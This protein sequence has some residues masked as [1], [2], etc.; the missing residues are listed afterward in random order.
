MKYK[1]THDPQ[2]HRQESRVLRHYLRL[3]LFEKVILINSIML[4]GEALAGLWVT[5][6]SLESHH[7]LID[8]SF[9]VIA[10]LCSLIINILVLRASFRPLFRLLATMHA[11]SEGKTG[12]RT[13]SSSDPDIGQLARAFNEM[14]DRLEVIQHEQT[15]QILQAQ[16]EERRR[17]ARELHDE[18]SQTLTALLIHNEIL[19]Q[20]LA[21]FSSTEIAPVAREQLDEGLHVFATLAQDTLD[22]IRVLSQQLRPSVLDDLG[23]EAALRWLVEDGQERLHLT[24]HIQIQHESTATQKMQLPPV[25]E[26]TLFRIA[27]EGLTNSARHAQ[28]QRVM[29][30]LDYDMKYIKLTI[31]DNGKGFDQTQTYSG[32]GIRGMRE[33]AAL[34]GGTLHIITGI[35]KGTTVEAILP[36]PTLERKLQ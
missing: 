33:R 32:L 2:H 13:P 10:T 26:T 27:Q 23:L 9:L 4:I 29:L 31:S 3:S 19:S 12:A 5:S 21:V 34:L 25:Y 28:A 6:H 36:L 20:R 17:I 22:K 11:V 18:T 7:Y 35:G 1:Q 14:L 24:A 8:V 15:M 30:K 16:E